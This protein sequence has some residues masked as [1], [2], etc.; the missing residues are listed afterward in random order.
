MKLN[1]LMITLFLTGMFFLALPG[2][3]V[4]QSGFGALSYQVSIPFGD[5]KT[6]ADKV[7][8]RGVGLDFRRFLDSGSTVG[9]TFGWNVIHERRTS[10]E[11]VTLNENPGAVTGVQDRTVNSF[12]I[13]LNVHKYLG[14]DGGNQPFLGLNAGGFIMRQRFNIGLQSFDENQWQWGVAPEIGVIIPVSLSSTV[15]INAKYYY[16]FTGNNVVGGDINHSYLSI[17]LGFAWENW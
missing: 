3:A 14:Q 7:S 9:L 15:M 4:A 8:W 12:P 1:K 6:F 2:Q 11:Q 10:T 16:A 17:G 13:M 5:T